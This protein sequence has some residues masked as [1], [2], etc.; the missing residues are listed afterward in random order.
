[1]SVE[2]NF[3]IESHRVNTTQNSYAFHAES[4]DMANNREKSTREAQQGKSHLTHGGDSKHSL[5]ITN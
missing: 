4:Q 1:M 5:V 3:T 2:G